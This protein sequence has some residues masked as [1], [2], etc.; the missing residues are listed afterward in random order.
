MEKVGFR[1]LRQAVI[2]G[3][4]FFFGWV[5]MSTFPIVH[6]PEHV[7]YDA[8]QRGAVAAFLV[9]IIAFLF[10]YQFWRRN[11]RLFA[12]EDILPP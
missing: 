2:C 1:L 10:F 12:L 3:I 4:I 8:C 11:K 5:I 9:T 6:A 7:L